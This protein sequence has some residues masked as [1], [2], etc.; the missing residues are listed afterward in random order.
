MKRIGK[1]TIATALCLLLALSAAGCM[2]RLP[3]RKERISFSIIS[4]SENRL[5]EEKIVNFAEK[6]G[7]DVTFTYA[8]TLDIMSQI[9][10]DEAYD[11]V[12]ASNSIW[13]YMLD[14]PG[15]V[16]N[17]KSTSITPVVFAID[18][19]KAQQL[20]YVEQSVSMEKI[21]SDIREKKFAFIMPSVTQTN[22]GASM[23]LGMLDTLSGNPE[24]LT[25]SHL[26]QEDL[27]EKLTSLFAGVERTSGDED[28][29][30]ALYQ[31]GNYD[32]VISYESSIIDI[33]RQLEQEGREPLYIIYPTE[34]VS[35]SDSPFA[36]I[37]RGQDKQEEFAVLQQFLLGEDMQ[38]SFEENGRRVWYGGTKADTDKT[39]FNPDWGIDTSAYLPT[40]KYPSVEVIKAALRLYQRDLKK[41]THTVFCLDF[42]GSMYGDGEAQLKEAMSYILTQESASADYLEFSSSD[43]VSVVPF[44]SDIRGMQTAEN[45]E[46]T[47]A[48]LD[49]V[50]SAEAG[51]GTDM[52][53]A[54]EGALE[55][56]SKED[57]SKYNLSI[58]LMTDGESYGGGQRSFERFYRELGRDIPVFSIMFGDANDE[59]LTEV[60]EFTNGRV[61]D[62]RKDLT[63]AFKVVRGYN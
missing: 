15:S 5:Y 48:L 17:A 30:G 21:V 52:Y 46:D 11:A 37:D 34:G 50:L 51:G 26:K 49:Y 13:L 41:P 38:A 16:K 19:Q 63:A 10:R 45:G 9:N 7:I 53:A 39:V 54:A 31:N 40:A 1:R 18:K 25:A 12:W 4:G 6:Q 28:F 59:Q 57:I 33:N 32:A 62:G 35:L 36:Y 20:G 14:S 47:G 43:K 27:K 22:A 2:G 56:L 29:L 24:I 8:G 44:D 23:Y 55:I 42:S 3:G 61:F 58:V 60:A